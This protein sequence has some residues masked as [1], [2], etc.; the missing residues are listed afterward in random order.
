MLHVPINRLLYRDTPSQRNQ[1]NTI[2]G[3]MSPNILDKLTVLTL[4]GVRRP[5]VNID[6]RSKLF[7]IVISINGTHDSNEMLKLLLTNYNLLKRNP[8][9][10]LTVT[11]LRVRED[12]TPLMSKQ[13]NELAL[14]GCQCYFIR[15]R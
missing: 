9:M 11:T 13:I 6:P 7:N 14:G 2:L 8:N 12:L 5:D 15:I 3:R 10:Y 1:V 4:G